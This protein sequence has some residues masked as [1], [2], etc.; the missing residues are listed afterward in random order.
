MDAAALSGFG[1]DAEVLMDELTKAF[2]NVW[3]PNCNKV[4]PMKI[5]VM[6]AND[7]NDHDAAD[8]L[9]G[10]CKFVVATLHAEP[11]TKFA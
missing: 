2:P 6:K 4:Q 1:A 5:A 9:C 8:I 3:C 11:V 7:R 10:E